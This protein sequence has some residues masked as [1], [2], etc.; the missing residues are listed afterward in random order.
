[1]TDRF[2]SRWLDIV[3]QG[4]LPAQY[5]QLESTGRLENFRCAARGDKGGF[6]GYRFNDSDVYKWLEAAA[7]AQLARP[8][9][10]LKESIG[11]LIG[12]IGPAQQADGYLNTY[13]QLE[14]P[15][16]R[17]RNLNSMHEMY[18]AGHLFEAA[19]ALHECLE[20]DRLL[21]I[22]CRFADHIMGI[23]GCGKKLG[24]P[25]H[26]EVE[27]GLLRLAAATGEQAYVDFARWLIDVRGSRPSPFAQEL[28]D[29][30]SLKLSPF[31]PGLFCKEGAYSGEYCQDHLPIRLHT[32]VVGHA[33]R[34]MYL[35]TAAAETCS[36]GDPE[37]V[38]ALERC[39]QNL[40]GRRMYVTG[41]I[42][43]SGENEGFSFDFDL[44]NLTAYAE[45][46]AACGLVFW[47]NAMLGAT[48]NSDYADVTER[49]LYNGAI[50]GISLDGERFF[51]TNP[52]ESRH[53]HE[54]QPWFACACCPP[55]I[56]RLVASVGRYV[57]GSDG[58][59][60]FLHIPAGFEAWPS[61]KGVKVQIQV[62]SDFP[63][64][65]DVRIL[66]DPAEPVDFALCVRIPEWA[67][68]LTSDLPGLVGESEFENGYAVFRK[69]W[70]RGDVLTLQF[71]MG[72]RWIAADPRVRDNIGRVAL[73]RGPLVY[74]AESVDLGFAP[75]LLMTDTERPIESQWSDQ[76]GGLV[77][78]SAEAL[79]QTE[80]AAGP[81]YTEDEAIE[82]RAAQPSLIP[83]YAW[84]NRGASDMQVW[85]RKA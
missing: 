41:G 19:A 34:A 35:Y 49:A 29:A 57:A 77:R 50:S 27:L 62:Q 24:Y 20:D 31:A 43:P 25:G 84:A 6:S 37:L 78:L 40:T 42:G 66:V 9:A 44:P 81:L 46:C 4:S 18:C 13:M 5:E 69:E 74:C 23:F 36:A 10:F 39:W 11:S 61:L 59:D 1:M 68:E 71:E 65:G 48:G 12:L 15:E 60:F 73:T 7:Y 14:H 72:P 85:F 22:A 17:W 30:E 80:T 76:L 55:N 3:A 33:V 75:Q 58:S 45:T 63:W 28:E 8:S 67:H 70:R 83:Y 47:G 2:W 38:A 54:R 56:A 21:P 51:Y 52:L 64:S 53:N 79:A 82:Y 16:M 32:E 26:E